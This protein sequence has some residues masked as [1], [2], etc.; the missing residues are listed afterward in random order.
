MSVV[1]TREAFFCWIVWMR[2]IHTP[3]ALFH[4]AEKKEFIVGSASPKTEKAMDQSHVPK[5]GWTIHREP[6]DRLYIYAPI[7]T[8][9]TNFRG[10]INL[11]D[12]RFLVCSVRFW[13]TLFFLQP[14]RSMT[15][16]CRGTAKV[17]QAIWENLINTAE[18]RLGSRHNYHNPQTQQS[19]IQVLTIQRHK[20]WF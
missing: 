10:T 6:G 19:S 16:F 12:S 13:K 9:L 4:Q 5:Q 7:V 20:Q 3:T 8:G 18:N 1:H 11:H 2:I 17:S 15:R 14:P